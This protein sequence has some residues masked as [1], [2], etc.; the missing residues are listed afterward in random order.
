MVVLLVVDVVD[1]QAND[2]QL[3][4]QLINPTSHWAMRS[5]SPM[6]QALSRFTSQTSAWLNGVTPHCRS[7]TSNCATRRAS[8]MLTT[9]SPFTS[10]H[11]TALNS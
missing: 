6:L 11:R 7:P 4:A 8:P 1:G 10:P 9:P 3:N 5:A 2:P